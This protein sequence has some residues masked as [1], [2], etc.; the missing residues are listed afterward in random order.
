MSMHGGGGG[1]MRSMR[2]DRAILE[3]HIKKGTLPRM[4]NFAT[5]YRTMLIIFLTAVVLDA[6]VSSVSPLILREIIDKGIYGHHH[7]THREHPVSYTH[8]TLPTIYSV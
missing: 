6:I 5:Q 2:R 1:G 4:L 3:H 7:V 8:L